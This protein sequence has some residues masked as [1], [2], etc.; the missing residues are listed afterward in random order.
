LDPPGD[1]P[2]LSVVV[3]LGAARPMR[4][5]RPGPGAP[6]YGCERTMLDGQ[7]AE[8]LEQLLPVARADRLG[9]ELDAV[10]RTPQV[11]H[12]HDHAVARPRGDLEVV[13][14][15]RGDAQRVVAD[16]LELLRDPGE[17]A[18]AVVPDRAQAP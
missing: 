18:R 11:A 9:M 12:A 14:R 1:E 4:N 2:H 17:Q 10:P 8:V 6:G 7:V 3:R 15:R 16:D 5:D 13:G